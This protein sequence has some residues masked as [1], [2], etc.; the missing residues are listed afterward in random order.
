MLGHAELILQQCSL[1]S[2]YDEVVLKA[3]ELAARD[4]ARGVLT[5]RQKAAM[6]TVLGELI[7]DL[8]DRSDAGT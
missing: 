4:A 8:S 1:S 2:Y 3:L 7:A 6:R 5:V